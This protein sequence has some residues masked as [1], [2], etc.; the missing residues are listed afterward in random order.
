[1][2]HPVDCPFVERLHLIGFDVDLGVV[3]CLDVFVLRLTASQVDSNSVIRLFLT[4]PLNSGMECVT[5]A[6]VR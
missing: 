2:R 3:H 6:T 5:I 4:F 1:M